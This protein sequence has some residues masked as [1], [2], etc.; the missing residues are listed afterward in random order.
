VG[1]IHKNFDYLHATCHFDFSQQIL[2]LPSKALESILAKNLV[3]SGSLYPLASLF[4]VRKFLQRGWRISAGQMLLIA[5]Q[6]ALIDFED[7][8]V[9]A[10]QLI[11]V[12]ASYMQALIIAL[13]NRPA[14]Q[15]I[16]HLY[17][18]NLIDE[19]FE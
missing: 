12:D 2:A 8:E 3:Y 13:K 14:G 17:L 5:H 11:G 7:T 9:L 10:E 16:D 19:I 1:E 15:R 18:T 4:R 6:I